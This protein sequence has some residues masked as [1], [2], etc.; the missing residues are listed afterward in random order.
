[1]FKKFEDCTNNEAFKYTHLY[2]GSKNVSTNKYNIFGE[3]RV[4]MVKL[5]QTMNFGVPV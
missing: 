1:V 4:F 3:F 5:Y 2:L